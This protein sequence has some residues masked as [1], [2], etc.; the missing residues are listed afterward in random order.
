MEGQAPP[1]STSPDSGKKEK[2]TIH[3]VNMTEITLLQANCSE[4]F[5]ASL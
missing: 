5:I 2:K 4:W 1:H 3:I